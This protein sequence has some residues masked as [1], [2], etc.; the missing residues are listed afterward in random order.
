VCGFE[1]VLP[2]G[3]VAQTGFARFANSQA[4]AVYRWG[5][6]PTLDGLFSQSNLG[7]VTRMTIWLMPAPPY[8]QAF[9]F[10]C[11]EDSQLA[12]LIEA[13]RPLRLSGALR[14]TVHIAN[15]YKVLAGLQQ[16][17]W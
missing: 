17:P 16:Y 11:G 8:F 3:D 14:S 7:I 12:P 15:D 6:G 9:F 10:Q 4:A 1:V 2:T 5:V 13:L